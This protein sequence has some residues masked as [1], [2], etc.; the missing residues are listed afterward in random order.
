MGE[1]NEAWKSNCNLGITPTTFKTPL[2]WRLTLFQLSPTI[3]KCRKIKVGQKFELTSLYAYWIIQMR[4]RWPISK[5]LDFRLSPEHSVSFLDQRLDIDP[6]PKETRKYLTSRR[7]GI[8]C[9]AMVGKLSSSYCVAHL[10]E[11]FFKESNMPET[12]LLR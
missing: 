1:N 2:Q 3:F 6:T 9:V 11:S 5:W 12:I 7:S 10:V 4:H 8:Q